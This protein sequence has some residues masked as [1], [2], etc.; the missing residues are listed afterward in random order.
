MACLDT[1]LLL[2]LR[3]RGGRK[4]QERARQKIL[5]LTR[6]GEDLAIT[7]FN[8]AELW[9]GIERAD[10]T[11]SVADPRRPTPAPRPAAPTGR[12]TLSAARR[13]LGAASCEVT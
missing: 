9:V 10:D 11:S 13:Q 2:D 7:V 12:P 8:L 3:G 5:Q 6:T 4:L 1:T